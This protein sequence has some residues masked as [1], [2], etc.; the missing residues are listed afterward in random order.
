MSPPLSAG[1]SSSAGSGGDLAQGG[2]A[3]PDQA[4]AL[5]FEESGAEADRH[6]QP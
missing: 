3:L 2:R 4:E 1:L 6:R 5:A